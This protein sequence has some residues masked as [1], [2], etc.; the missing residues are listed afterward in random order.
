MNE[1]K[2]NRI[3]AA[4]TVNTILL[5]VILVAVVIYQLVILTGYANRKN[6]ILA[7]IAYYE[8]LIESG[9]NDLE[10]LQSYKHL[11]DLAIEYGYR[12]PNE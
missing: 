7:E 2:R 1:E 5:I 8:Q 4:A 6:Q 11:R 3:V 9:S 12:F 10:F